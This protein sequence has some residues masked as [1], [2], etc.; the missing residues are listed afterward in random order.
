M[1]TADQAICIVLAM[2]ALGALWF[3]F[4]AYDYPES[5]D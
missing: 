1:I 5:E 2:V 4:E 3:G